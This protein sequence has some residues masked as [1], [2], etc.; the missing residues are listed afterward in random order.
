MSYNHAV[1]TEVASERALL[2]RTRFSMSRPPCFAGDREQFVEGIETAIG[3]QCARTVIISSI[4]IVSHIN[5]I[6]IEILD[7]GRSILQ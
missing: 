6:D 2:A 4:D 7:S 3:H 1:F 5:P